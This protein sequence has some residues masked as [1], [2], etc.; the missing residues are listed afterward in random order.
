MN[1]LASRSSVDAVF[2]V[3]VLVLG[4]LVELPSTSSFFVFLRVLSLFAIGSDSSGSTMGRFPAAIVLRDSV[5]CAGLCIS[6]ASSKLSTLPSCEV[7]RWEL[8]TFSIIWRE[9]STLSGSLAALGTCDDGVMVWVAVCVVALVRGTSG[10]GS[11]S[12]SS[13]KTDRLWILEG[14]LGKRVFGEV[15]FEEGVKDEEVG[16]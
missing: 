5:P 16:E 12:S 10:E 14:G 7:P 8:T 2:L 9:S 1:G 13:T 4:P 15:C 11:L 6:R 3:T